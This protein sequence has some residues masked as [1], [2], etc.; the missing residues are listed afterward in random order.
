MAPPVLTWVINPTTV[1]SL[2]AGYNHWFEGNVVQG[3]PFDM[4]QSRPACVHQLNFE[5]VPGCQRRAGMRRW[6]RRIGAGQGG[7]PRNDLT[8][9]ASL[10]KMVGSHCLAVGLHGS[11]NPDWRRTNLPHHIQLRSDSTAG[12]NPQTA[13]TATS[14]DAFASMLLGVGTGGSTGVSVLPFT[15]KHY[16]GTYLQDD[17]KITRKLTLNLGIR[18]EYQT[19][20]VDRFNQQNFFDFNATNPISSTLGTTV[21]GAVVYNG[22]SGVAARTLQPDE[23]GLRSAARPGLS[24]HG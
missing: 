12:P 8:W 19:A 24:G 13:S 23:E 22:V 6:V 11:R 16:Y 18:W 3:Y 10:N 5:P 4:T 21:K 14:G 2:N 15:S 20:P 9:S 1:F 17:W 7:F